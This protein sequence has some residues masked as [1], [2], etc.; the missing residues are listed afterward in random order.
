MM[1]EEQDGVQ[2]NGKVG[3][4]GAGDVESIARCV[5]HGQGD[6]FREQVI[7]QVLVLTLAD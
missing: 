4:L 1:S 5:K 3:V 6:R 2:T 7:S